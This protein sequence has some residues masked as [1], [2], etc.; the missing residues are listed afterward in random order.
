MGGALWLWAIGF[1]QVMGFVAVA[2]YVQLGGE[3]GGNELLQG[4]WLF[5]CCGV[6]CLWSVVSFGIFFKMINKGYGQTFYWSITGKNF[7]VLCYRDSTRD[8]QKFNVFG[9]HRSYYSSIESELK[10]WVCENWDAWM[11]GKEDG[12]APWF[13][14]RLVPRDLRPASS[15]TRRITSSKRHSSRKGTTETEN[16]S[17]STG[18]LKGDSK[19]KEDDEDR[20]FD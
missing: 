17:G 19:A 2:L 18:I 3:S 11:I 13:D 15:S 14:S 1:S 5:T 10:D 20:T 6:I 7:A 12:T 4:R 8:E 9:H 16:A